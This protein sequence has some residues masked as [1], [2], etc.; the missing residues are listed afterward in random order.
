M[1]ETSRDDHGALVGWSA[2]DLG[3]KLT[4]RM[5]SVTKPPPH[6]GADIHSFLYV[7][8]RNQAVQ[9]GNYLFEIIGQT[10][11]RK[12]KKGWLDRLLNP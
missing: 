1:D 12:R 5:Q 3:G 11:P 2:Q 9:L 6:T 10:P 7:M 4:L 8:D